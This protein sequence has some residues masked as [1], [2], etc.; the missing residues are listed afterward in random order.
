MPDGVAYRWG[1]P[2]AVREVPLRMATGPDRPC[3]DAP[4]RDARRGRATTRDAAPRCRGR[5][6]AE[7]RRSVSPD[8]RQEAAFLARGS[9]GSRAEIATARV[10]LKSA[11]MAK[12]WP[13]SATDG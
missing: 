2:S 4:S 5:G 1:P 7:R 10:T 12:A 8:L 3:R 11:A 13:N 6:A 9:T